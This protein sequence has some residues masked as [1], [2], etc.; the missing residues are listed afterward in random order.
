MNGNR[1]HLAAQARNLSLIWNCLSHPPFIYRPRS[2]TVDSAVHRCLVPIPHCVPVAVAC[3]SSP[4]LRSGILET[5]SRFPAIGLQVPRPQH[6]CQSGVSKGQAWVLF[7]SCSECLGDFSRSSC[8]LVR[9]VTLVVTSRGK[10][11]PF[12]DVC[13]PPKE[14]HRLNVHFSEHGML[15]QLLLWRCPCLS[16]LLEGLST[17]LCHPSKLTQVSLPLGLFPPALAQGHLGARAYPV[18]HFPTTLG[19]LRMGLCLC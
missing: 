14:P 3:F 15:I 16:F 12:L 17:Y 19:T 2:R 18:E 10:R 1:H 13:V 9:P 5:H 4:S 7:I 8:P 11:L 6:C